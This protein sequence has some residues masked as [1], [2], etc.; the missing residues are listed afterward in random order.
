MI[1]LSALLCGLLLV[2]PLSACVSSTLDSNQFRPVGGMQS[3]AQPEPA[4]LDTP[5]IPVSLSSPING[6]EPAPSLANTEA[7]ESG[8]VLDPSA[9]KQAIDEMRAKA[10]NGSGVRTQ[11]GAIPA[12]A[13]ERLDEAGR[14]RLESELRQSSSDAD[15]A[16]SDDELN[17]KKRSIE[18]MRRKATR[19]FD[20]ALQTIEN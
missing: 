15:A 3:A 13:T 9:R 16:I 6:R 19:H 8:S 5:E 18:Q 4:R 17:A 11:I 1:R 10:A 2:V 7:S 14:Q 12:T 20:D